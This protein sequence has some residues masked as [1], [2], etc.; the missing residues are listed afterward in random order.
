MEKKYCPKCGTELAIDA[1]FCKKCGVNINEALQQSNH[2]PKREDIT[3]STSSI[4]KKHKKFGL[5]EYVAITLIL[6]GIIS[7]FKPENSSSNND[8]GSKEYSYSSSKDNDDKSEA[9]R[10][11]AKSY[12]DQ[13]I[14]IKNA[15]D[16]FEEAISLAENSISIYA[17]DYYQK[18]SKY[19]VEYYDH[20]LEAAQMA[21]KMG[22]HDDANEFEEDA[23]KF[24]QSFINYARSKGM[25]A[26]WID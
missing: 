2:A 4:K 6:L 26:P 8:S 19:G 22:K 9:E 18:A 24:K 11:M 17:I 15:R 25:P 1:L 5:V 21:R 10:E 7:L 16:S 23:R 12:V 13:I 3:E 14:K 20:L